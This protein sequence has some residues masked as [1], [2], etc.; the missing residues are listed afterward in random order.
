MAIRAAWS[1]ASAIALASVGVLPIKVIL[2]GRRVA[3]GRKGSLNG[4]FWRPSL[5]MRSFWLEAG[6]ENCKAISSERSLIIE[7]EGR[8]RVCGFP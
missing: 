7:S 1:P 5:A 6:M 3:I 8:R 4:G 2:C